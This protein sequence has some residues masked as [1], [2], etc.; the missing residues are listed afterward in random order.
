MFIYMTLDNYDKLPYGIVYVH[1]NK[2]NGKAYVGQTR[3]DP[4]RRFKNESNGISSYASCKAFYRALKKYSWD[5]FET[6]ILASAKTQIDLNWLEEYF[7]NYYSALLPNGY[8]SVLQTPERV[9]FTQEV[10][11]KIS[12]AN[13]RPTGKPAWNAFRI[14]MVEGRPHKKCGLCKRLL[15]TSNF[16]EIRKRRGVVL[17][18]PKL[19]PRCRECNNAYSSKYVKYTRLTQ[20]E[21]RTRLDAKNARIS[22]TISAKFKKDPEYKKKLRDAIKKSLVAV[23]VDSDKTTLVFDA[24]IEATAAGY[25]N[26]PIKKSIDSGKPYKGYVWKR[27]PDLEQDMA[28]ALGVSGINVLKSVAISDYKLDLKD[29]QLRGKMVIWKHEWLNRR[30]QVLNFLKP[31][32]GLSTTIGARKCEFRPVDWTTAR[33]FCEANHIQGAPQHSKLSLGAFYNNEL[34]GLATFSSHHRNSNEIVLS[35]LC[36]KDDIS[37]AGALSKFS[38]IATKHF[39]TAIYTWVHKTLSDGQSYVKAG[40][41]VVNVLAPDYFYV[42]SQDGSV[43]SKQSR[44]KRLV[45]TP[46]GMTELEHATK[47]GFKRVYDC[48]KIK[49]V[50]SGN[51]Y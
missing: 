16:S 13:K 19:N 25:Q 33:D 50:Y 12:A 37:V 35:R 5:G 1:I 48:G 38:K 28:S 30:K 29:P 2:H 21:K 27:M 34:V 17:E 51:K 7:I 9:I 36:F 11:D 14:E 43:V 3:Q 24:G 46:A 8:N 4:A 41:E 18:Q 26:T 20:E 40:W 49:L 22:A 44:Q 42:S 47:D 15:P 10:R 45:N 23:P 39:N 31:K 32:L 6:S